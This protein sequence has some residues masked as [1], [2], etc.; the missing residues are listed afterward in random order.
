MRF[1]VLTIFPE[2]VRAAFAEGGVGRALRSEI[3][4][5][6]VQEAGA[7]FDAAERM[8]GQKPDPLDLANLRADQARRAGL[9]NRPEESERLAREALSALGDDHPAEHGVV[10]VILAEALAQQEKP[11]ANETFERAVELIEKHGRQV[12]KADAFRAWARYLRK[13]GRESEALDVL[14][15]AAQLSASKPV[16]SRG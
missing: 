13:S 15:R 14:D 2:M 7:Q 16:Q 5:L 8:F 11:E 10:L 9:L 1:D 12:E 3:L 6:Q 4:S